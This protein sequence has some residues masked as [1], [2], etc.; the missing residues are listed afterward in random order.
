MFS[1]VWK[2]QIKPIIKSISINVEVEVNK[3]ELAILWE[4][5]I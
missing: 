3:L 1:K 4:R 2:T 5:C